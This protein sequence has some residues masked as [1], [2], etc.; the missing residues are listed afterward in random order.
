[1]GSDLLRSPRPVSLSEEDFL[2]CAF[3]S[4]LLS[5]LSEKLAERGGELLV[6]AGRGS[7][8]LAKARPPASSLAVFPLVSSCV[9]ASTILQAR[10]E[11]WSTH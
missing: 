8:V 3:F 9:D 11:V 4:A 10:E 7:S 6:G 5:C 1:M 2:C